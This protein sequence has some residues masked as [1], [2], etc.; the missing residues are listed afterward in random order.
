M[1]CVFVCAFCAAACVFTRC[2]L[3]TQTQATTKTF[4]KQNKTKQK[5]R[6]LLAIAPTGSGKTLAFLL[7]VVAALKRARGAG[8]DAWP[9]APKALLLSPTHELA[10]QARHVM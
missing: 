3:A 4:Q 6:E 9:D 8:G 7:P 1:R 5:G 10:A 2:P